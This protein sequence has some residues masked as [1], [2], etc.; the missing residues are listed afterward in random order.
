MQVFSAVMSDY[1]CCALVHSMF[2]LGASLVLP[3]AQRGGF[4]RFDACYIINGSLAGHISTAERLQ[5]RECFF[6]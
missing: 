3:G 1:I 2:R 4:L 5:V 6:G